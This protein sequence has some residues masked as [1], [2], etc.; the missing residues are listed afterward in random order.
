[1]PSC[2]VRLEVSM[3]VQASKLSPAALTD[4]Q[5]LVL[6]TYPMVIIDLIIGAIAKLTL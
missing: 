3:M 2:L 4:A 6:R 1:M 5:V